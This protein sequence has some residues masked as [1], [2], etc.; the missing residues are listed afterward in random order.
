MTLGDAGRLEGT[1]VGGIAV[2]CVISWTERGV[3][4]SVVA[5][6]DAA[7]ED[8]LPGLAGLLLLLL[9]CARRNR[10]EPWDFFMP[11]M[12]TMLVLLALRLMLVDVVPILKSVSY[13]SRS[14]A[15]E[16]MVSMYGE[17][18]LNRGL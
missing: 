4:G 8:A 1:G 5:L 2:G 17:M 11:D 18:C 14:F 12:L 6:L 10:T 9:L 3:L 13:R 7:M 15:R 16:N